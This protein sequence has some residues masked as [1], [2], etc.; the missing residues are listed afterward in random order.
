MSA[1]DGDFDHASAVELA[2]AISEGRTTSADVTASAIARLKPVHEACNAVITFEDDEALEAA[3]KAD[4][5]VKS[6]AKLGPLHGVPL[7]HK[8]MF[9]RAGKIASWGANIR[10]SEAATETAAVLAGLQ[11]VGAH[12]IAALH[13]TEFAFGPTGHNYIIGHARNPHNRDLITG[14]SS[15]GSA[16]CVATGVVP[17]A[18][19]SDTAGSL[20]LPAA[21]CGVKSLKPTWGRVSLAGAMPLSG[22]HDCVGPIAR[23]AE[24]LA[25]L[26]TAIA[27]PDP[28]DGR[29]M[30]VPV[31]DYAAALD[32]DV[33]ALTIGVDDRLVAEAGSDVQKRF[34]DARRVFA[35][36][37][38]RFQSVSFRDWGEIDRLAQLLQMPEVA[39][40]HGAYLR[41]RADDYGPQV[42]ARV[43]VGHFVSGADHQTALR[44]RG[45]TLREVLQ[46]TY[47]ACDAVLLPVFPDAVPT[48][49]ELDLADRPELL[50]ALARVLLYTRAVNY[51]A[52]P[53]VTL[54]YARTD[55]EM[56]NGFQLVGRPFREDQLLTFAAAY[57]RAVPPDVA[58]L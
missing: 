1:S 2:R 45:M 3:G 27:G 41:N 19:G 37:G 31:P 34:E 43:E 23:H 21:A 33:T 47:G 20:R 49:D 39:S 30:D 25:A 4:A 15:S 17:A 7:A 54:P 16:I 12:Q 38:C 55:A 18:L 6:G 24:D 51:L 8:D 9:D 52:L 11:N 32:A 42:R 29:A 36:A 46:E 44:A 5:A 56:P 14:G 22:N 40:A 57:E 58:K 50:P 35:D 10:R 28:K 53:A 48:V 26:L 13:M